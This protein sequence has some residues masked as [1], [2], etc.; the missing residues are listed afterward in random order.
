MNE[1]ETPESN[2]T[3]TPVNETETP[4]SNT[5]ETSVNETETPESNTTETSVNETETPES[6]ST[7][8]PVNETETPESN[9]TETPVNETETPKSNS[10]ETPVNETETPETNET[11]TPRANDS[12]IQA[13]ATNGTVE[14]ALSGSVSITSVNTTVYDVPV[15]SIASGQPVSVTVDYS[16]SGQSSYE[17]WIYEE[18]VTELSDE[19]L[20]SK[21][22]TSD[23][24]ETTIRVPG[25]ELDDAAS[26]ESFTDP[27]VELRAV[28]LRGFLKDDIE[29]TSVNKGRTSSTIYLADDSVETPV[30][31]GDTTRVTLFGWGSDTFAGWEL[32]E[33]DLLSNP[34]VASGSARTNSSGYFEQ[35]VQYTPSEYRSGVG[36]PPIEIY[37][38]SDDSSDTTRQF[39]VGVT[40]S[41]DPPVIDDISFDP[42]VPNPDDRNGNNGETVTM[43]ASASDDNRI[44]SYD[45]DVDGDGQ[46]EYSGESIDIVYRDGGDYDVTLRVTDSSGQ[47]VTEGETLHVNRRPYPRIDGPGSVVSAPAGGSATVTLDIYDSMDPDGNIDYSGTTWVV[48]GIDGTDF[49][50][51]TYTDRGG[52]LRL[53]LPAGDY[54]VEAYVEDDNGF[55]A[56]TN[57]VGESVEFEVNARPSVAA[58]GPNEVNEGRSFTLQA[59]GSDDNGDSLSY[60]WTQT[61][62]PGTAEGSGSSVTFEAPE[63]D[64]SSRQLTFEVTADDG[65]ATASDTVTVTV[66]NTNAQPTAE[67]AATPTEIDEGQSVTLD[68]SG[69]SDPDGTSLSYAWEVVSAPTSDAPTPSGA[70]GDVT[71]TTPGEYTY[72][73]TVTD[74]GG[75]SDTATVTVSVADVNPAPTASLTASS[76]TI[77]EGQSVTLDASDSSDPEGEQLAYSWRVLSA[78]AG[79]APTPSGASGSVTLATPGEYT[80]EVTVTDRDG[81]GKSDTDTV[82]VTVADVNPTPTASLTAS[83]SAIDEGQSITLDAS[84]S[85]DPEGEALTYSW[86]VV[87]AP[88]DNAPTPSGSGGDVTLTTPGEYTYEVTV[89]DRGGDGKSDT[90]TVTVNVG[91]VNEAPTAEVE[92]FPSTIDEGQSV[93][94]DASDSS[95]PEGSRLTYDWRVQSAP[96]DNAPTP[97]GSGGDVTLTT[98]GEYT[99]EVTVT[100]RSGDGK[101]DTATVTVNVGDVNKAPAASVTAS[102]DEVRVG[103]DVTFDATD[104][105]DPEGEQLA[106]DWEVVSAPT[107]DAPT[108]SGASGS[109]TLTTPGEYIYE[110]TVTDRGGDGKSDTATV[111]VTVSNETGTTVDLRSDSVATTG[112]RTNVSVVV[113]Q[114]TDGVRSY[115]VTLYVS[116]ASV[117]AV[118]DVSFAGDPQFSNANVSDGG[119]SV[120][121]TAG[122]ANT[123]DNGSVVIANVTL[124]ADAAGTTDVRATVQALGDENNDAYVVTAV[125]NTTVTVESGPPAIGSDRNSPTD[126]DDD[127]VYEDVN[128]DGEFNVIDVSAL[129]DNRNDAAVQEH[130]RFFD[131]NGDGA[132]NVIDVSALFDQL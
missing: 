85:S 13:Q 18:D 84:D 64:S 89:T 125:N 101:S 79:D 129:F 122:A 48:A 121:V 33:D 40:E 81:D 20:A 27:G 76:S 107:S 58:S 56:L 42:S 45:W 105:S 53:D 44:R 9:T 6:N 120:R 127:G 65:H 104:S 117:A 49:A 130:G 39:T 86:E 66:Q 38:A 103:S 116:N 32:R 57:R 25:D 4:E 55:R 99:Y 1:T 69:S 63:I 123:A 7:E 59:S 28:V 98:P 102:P 2:T 22:V 108:P 14:A 109:V 31:E 113:Q 8:T 80:Y 88:V 132:F 41:D 112:Q 23:S 126:P 35:D 50:T 26:D 67:L 19:Q 119:T 82:T 106:Y 124:L 70:N 62:G 111:I 110:V 94:L 128:G 131:F 47:S 75:K 51:E 71:L 95:D 46:Y 114:A 52:E 91:D 12:D 92:A 17:I 36:D 54:R 118:E 93:T 90:A 77:D 83:P 5:T 78:P 3:E 60:S 43:T 115:D 16:L 72:E 97:S 10:T 21:T 61:S 30:V 11:E 15:D 73:V 87:S 34:L 100:D 74:R 24:G 29:S 37:A 96:V 68:A